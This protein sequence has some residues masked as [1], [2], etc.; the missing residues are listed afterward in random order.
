MSGTYLIDHIKDLGKNVNA[1][2]G[3]DGGF[4]KCACFLQNRS[5]LQVLERVRIAWW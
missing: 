1:L 5:F 2:F 3:V 4:V